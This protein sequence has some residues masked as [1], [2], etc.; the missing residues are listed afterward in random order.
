M[1]KENDLNKP[2]NKNEL[3]NLLNEN[4]DYT[5]NQVMKTNYPLIE[6]IRN[7]LSEEYDIN[8]EKY[9][10]KDVGNYLILMLQWLINNK[11]AVFIKEYYYDINVK[12]TI[13][14]DTI[15]TRFLKRPKLQKI[16]NYMNDVLEMRL[17][18][19]ALKGTYKENFTKFLMIN[20][21]GYKSEKVDQDINLTNKNIRFDFGN[22]G[23][24]EEKGKDE[25]VNE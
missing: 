14:W 8:V 2:S 22:E 6:E 7:S 11:D 20:N 18:K 1:S 9:T 17:A 3:E 13:P 15:K 19:A 21:F 16:R 25:E 23:L 10:D 24:I 4:F 5:E 12:Y